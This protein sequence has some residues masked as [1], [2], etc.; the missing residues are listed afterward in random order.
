MIDLGLSPIPTRRAVALA[1]LLSILVAGVAVV[2]RWNALGSIPHGWDAQGY[3][4][5]SRVFA[6]GRLTGPADEFE[7]FFRGPQVVVVEDRKFAIYP[8]GWPAMLSIAQFMGAPMAAEFVLCSLFL[9]GVWTL[10]WRLFG[11]TSAWMTLGATAF[12]PFVLFMAGSYLSHLPAAVA[13]IGVNLSLL[14][15]ADAKSRR[16]TTV[17]GALAGLCAGVAFQCRPMTAS[18]GVIATVLMMSLIFWKRPRSLLISCAAAIPTGLL[19]A[20]LLLM[21]NLETTGSYLTTGYHIVESGIGG[22]RS[23][24]AGNEIFA[25]SNWSK[26]MP[27]YIRHLNNEVW[28]GLTPDWLWPLLGLTLCRRQLKA[29]AVFLA[30][31]FFLAGHAFY[32]Y[33]DLYFGP[34]MLFES[35]PWFFVLT[36]AGLGSMAT[37][38]RHHSRKWPAITGLVVGVVNAAFVIS[39]SIPYFYSYYAANYSGNSQDLVR[40]VR[41]R[42]PDDAAVLVQD[43]GISLFATFFNQN[44]VDLSTSRPL[45]VRVNSGNVGRLQDCLDKYPRREKW[46]LAYQFDPAEGRNI[47]PDRFSLR[48]FELFKLD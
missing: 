17:L 24:G 44:A 6:A 11:S 27:L 5:Q 4:Y 26:N 41:K 38:S 23:I 42:I 9:L 7:D 18:L 33:F 34:R 30:L 39:F 29:Y 48:Q 10:G 37:F 8:P 20:S 31:A 22:N 12:S 43:P 46:A 3:V 25:T 28:K 45:F 1:L 36:G 32:H 2:L 21:W 35:M 19:V 40:D 13:L 47:Y 15:A 16:R 14:N